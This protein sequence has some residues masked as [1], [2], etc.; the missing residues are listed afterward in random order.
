MCISN[1]VCTLFFFY[2]CILHTS[3]RKCIYI[4][5]HYI[6]FSLL[7]LLLLI[8]LYCIVQNVCFTMYRIVINYCIYSAYIYIQ[9][10]KWAPHSVH[11]HTADHLANVSIDPTITEDNKKPKTN[12]NEIWLAPVA[13]F[14][15]YDTPNTPPNSRLFLQYCH[16]FGVCLS[17][18]SS[19]CQ[20]IP[21][22]LE[23]VL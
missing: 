23:S 22:N 19:R 2:T 16:Y 10:L 18:T 9:F 7:L 17:D 3:E 15:A 4:Y 20:H 21:R 5:I 12:D 8:I 6:I 14:L 1:N 11:R 13:C